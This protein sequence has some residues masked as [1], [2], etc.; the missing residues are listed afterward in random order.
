[1]PLESWWNQLYGLTDSFQV[2]E[3][4]RLEIGG[5]PV[6]KVLAGSDDWEIPGL[7]K[8][9]GLGQYGMSL[10]V[11]V[12]GICGL[13]A[14]M[15][16]DD[17]GAN[18]WI[19][20]QSSWSKALVPTTAWAREKV[21]ALRGIIPPG[22]VAP[23]MILP[24]MHSEDARLTGSLWDANRV[25]YYLTQMYLDGDVD[26][27]QSILA[28]YHQTGDVMDT[29]R[30][31]HA[32][33]RAF[34][35]YQ[36][37]LLGTAFKPRADWEIYVGEMWEASSSLWK[38]KRDA[39]VS[40]DEY[41][42]AWATFRARYPEYSII[43]MVRGDEADR[44]ESLVWWGLSNLPPGYE[45]RELLDSYA[46]DSLLS[47]FYDVKGDLSQFTPANRQRLVAA[48]LDIVTDMEQPSEDDKEEWAEVKK[49]RSEMTVA[50]RALF[51]EDI[52]DV[53]GAYYTILEEKG[54]EAARAF[55]EEF[56]QLGEYQQW[57]GD[58]Y[59][60]DPLL[61]EYYISRESALQSAAWDTYSSVP[62]G[63]RKDDYIEAL[64][65][66]YRNF[67][68]L[69]A[70]GS[71]GEMFRTPA[72]FEAYVAA[73]Q[74]VAD[75]MF[76]GEV[77]D[78]MRAEWA[79]V[80]ET[81]SEYF[82]VRDRLF[83]L[84]GQGRYWDM[85]KADRRAYGAWKDE[86]AAGHP[87]WAHYYVRPEDEEG[88]GTGTGRGGGG[89]ARGG[90]GRRGGGWGGRRGGGRAPAA[91]VATWG[92]LMGQMGDLRNIAVASLSTYFTSGRALPATLRAKLEAAYGKSK[93]GYGTFEEW[94]DEYVRG[95]WNAFLRKTRFPA[96]KGEQAFGGRYG[97]GRGYRPRGSRRGRA[98]N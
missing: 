3:Q 61:K 53:E 62:P 57:R 74:G 26:E 47:K 39:T 16:G 51:G 49:L 18:A 28:A 84:V 20:W 96:M 87:L 11:L 46:L 4:R 70:A 36:A 2:E 58:Y 25:G 33:G 66:E 85:S 91:P 9:Q 80:K 44:Q 86:W 13:A 97:G 19:N 77:T 34:P 78:E 60:A 63:Y 48:M 10:S 23:E 83:P 64:P 76:P 52:L 56:P 72:E 40:P 32:L 30:Q 95:L 5:L 42:A 8:W 12:T 82:D 29:A 92:D 22:G 17:R 41:S 68:K 69:W 71:G 35:A 31:Q 93:M 59:E 43:K 45:R 15:Q 73:T 65:W 88:A 90:G 67:F 7:G 1:M 89:R 94:L 81:N 79:G 38:A 54:P 6:G 50:A 21:P 24:W 98:R 37:L 75:E 14:Y 27:R 55:K